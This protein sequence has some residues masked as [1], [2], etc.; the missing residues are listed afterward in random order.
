M[1]QAEHFYAKDRTEWWNWLSH[2]YQ[3]HTAVW[4]IFDKGKNKQLTYDDIVE[5][6]LCFGWVDSRPGKVDETRTKLYISQRKPKSAWSKS[7]KVRVAHLIKQE[8]MQPSGLS[9]IKV[10]QANGAWD[11]LNKS[12][13]FIIPKEMSAL[14]KTNSTA[15]ANYNNFSPSSKRIILEWIY[16]AKQ[17]GTKLKRIQETVELAEKNI[18]ANH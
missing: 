18:K 7:N 6:A 14:F 16:A 1:D 9:A 12:D 3:T 2:N 8:L 17:E 5:V 4:L 10:A 13:K 11:A 15:E